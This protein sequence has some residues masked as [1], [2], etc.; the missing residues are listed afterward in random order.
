MA[1]KPKFKSRTKEGTH[2]AASALRKVG[3]L[4]KIAVREFDESCLVVAAEI[5]PTQIKRL[6]EANHVR[7]PA[8]AR[9]LGARENMIM[10]WEN[11]A[12]KRRGT[13]LKL[14]ALVRKH[15]LYVLR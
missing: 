5:R 13:A 4:G 8:F 7:Q 9:Y 10:Q 15:G 12:M 14:L 3:A 11:G 2:A 6:R 1:T